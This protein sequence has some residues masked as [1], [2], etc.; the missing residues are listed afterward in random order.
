LLRR[1][2]CT[3]GTVELEVEYAPRPEYGR[4]WPELRAVEGGVL[5]TGG[6]DWLLRLSC[7]PH[8]VVDAS[9]RARLSL[10]AGESRAWALQYG[11]AGGTA[12]F[13]NEGRIADRLRETVAAWRSWSSEHQRYQGPWRDLVDLSGRVLQGLTYQPSGAIVAAPTTSLP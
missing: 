9:A 6:D 5:A 1:A 7:V 10:H 11:T 13:W 4:V 3:G 12:G 2:E 8:D